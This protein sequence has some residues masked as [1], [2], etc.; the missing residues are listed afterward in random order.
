M[1]VVECWIEGEVWFAKMRHPSWP[2]DWT[3]SGSITKRG[4]LRAV[5]RFLNCMNPVEEVIIVNKN[6]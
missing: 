4:L 1:I 5:Y 3:S 2:T 6:E